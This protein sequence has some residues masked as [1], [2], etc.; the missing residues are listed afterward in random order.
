[1]NIYTATNKFHWAIQFPAPIKRLLGK[2]GMAAT[3]PDR[4]SDRFGS[5]YSL[6]GGRFKP[7]DIP[8]EILVWSR[9][10]T[11]ICAVENHWICMN[12][13]STAS[14]FYLL[15][16]YLRVFLVQMCFSCLWA[17]SVLRV[18][19]MRPFSCPEKYLE[20]GPGRSSSQ[21]ARCQSSKDDGIFQAINI[22][23]WEIT[24]NHQSF[25]VFLGGLR[26]QNGDGSKLVSCWSVDLDS[27][28]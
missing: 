2:G 8:C 22:S 27:P 3:K 4:R 28:Q 18:W 12:M 14:S 17:T 11:N 24:I 15:P 1:M 19:S 16:I 20:P 23:Q 9:K 5:Y 7:W 26:L 21:V 6:T 25:P 13:Q 10:L